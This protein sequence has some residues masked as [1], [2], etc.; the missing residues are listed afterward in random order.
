MWDD[1]DERKGE[2]ETRCWLIACSS[3]KAPRGLRGLTSPSDG[4]I[5]IVGLEEMVLFSG[6]LVEGQ[7]F[8]VCVQLQ[9]VFVSCGINSL[10]RKKELAYNVLNHQT[11]PDI[12]FGTVTSHLRMDDKRGWRSPVSCSEVSLHLNVRSGLNSCSDTIFGSNVLV[13]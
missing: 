2:G 4:R 9:H 5:A 7:P 1:D 8:E 13:T 10:F 11:A 6:L 3:Q 12:K